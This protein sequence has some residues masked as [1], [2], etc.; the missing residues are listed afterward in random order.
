MKRWFGLDDHPTAPSPMQIQVLIEVNLLELNLALLDASRPSPMCRNID[1]TR[2]RAKAWLQSFKRRPIFDR[3][4]WDEVSWE[5]R[6]LN[7]EMKAAMVGWT[8]LSDAS[9]RRH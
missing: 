5:A 1:A 3:L 9:R 6:I 7:R 4:D 2:A 8:P